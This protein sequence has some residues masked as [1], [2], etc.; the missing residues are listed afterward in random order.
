MRGKPATLK[1]RT[2][3]C[4]GTEN[5]FL[6]G[7]TKVVSKYGNQTDVTLFEVRHVDCGRDFFTNHPDSVKL[8]TLQLDLPLKSAVG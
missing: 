4:K 1:C 2:K 5:L 6:T 8:P 3:E 7:V